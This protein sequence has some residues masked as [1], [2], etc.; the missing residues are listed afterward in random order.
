MVRQPLDVLG[1]SVRIGAFDGADDASMQGLAP[2]L[3]QGAVRDVM[4]ERV[5][6]GVREVRIEPRLVE[7]LG[8]LE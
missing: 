8:G 7:E 4:G 3:E 2:V 5:L 1:Q 6:E